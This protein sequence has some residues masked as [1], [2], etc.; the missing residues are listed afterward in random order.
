MKMNLTDEVL[1]S[2]TPSA[3]T[4][5]VKRRPGRPRRTEDYTCVSVTISSDL[6]R[7][8]DEMARQWG[9]NRSGAVTRILTAE[10]EHSQ[11]NSSLE[12]ENALARIGKIVS[13]HV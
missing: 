6:I 5:Q 2:E 7:K 3:E 4:E 8:I 10:I 1:S 11:I 9:V 13:N 12:L